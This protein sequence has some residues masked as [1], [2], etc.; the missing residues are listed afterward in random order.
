MINLTYIFTLSISL[1]L[2]TSCSDSDSDNVKVP[3]ENTVFDSQINSNKSIATHII[4]VQCNGEFLPLRNRILSKEELL[5]SQNGSEAAKKLNSDAIIDR[6]RNGQSVRVIKTDTSGYHLVE[7]INTSK[8]SGNL[9]MKGYVVSKYCQKP[10]LRKLEKTAI[11]EFQESKETGS[12]LEFISYYKPDGDLLDY[13]FA[14]VTSEAD[15]IQVLSF[16]FTSLNEIY[17]QIY[18]VNLQRTSLLFNGSAVLQNEYLDSN[19]KRVSSYLAEKFMGHGI[20]IH[21]TEDGESSFLI[22]D[23]P[24]DSNFFQAPRSMEEKVVMQRIK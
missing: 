5:I 1:L 17:Y 18:V 23:H 16:D 7:V 9:T 20:E 19:K 24:F 10:T 22:M 2:I 14:Y 3:A 8:H 21:I 15:F 6:L 4:D 11:P 12:M 13:S